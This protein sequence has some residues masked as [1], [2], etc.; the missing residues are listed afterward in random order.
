MHFC[1]CFSLGCFSL[2][3]LYSSNKY[4]KFSCCFLLHFGHRRQ[5]ACLNLHSRRQI[6]RKNKSR[7]F[8]GNN[9]T[10]TMPQKLFYN[11]SFSEATIVNFD[12]FGDVYVYTFIFK[13]TC[14]RDI[15]ERMKGIVMECKGDYNEAY[16]S[17]QSTYFFMCLFNHFNHFWP[18]SDWHIVK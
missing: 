8:L 10:N 17:F 1:C 12:F 11:S 18:F 5:R 3:I 9:G 16:F 6:S 2:F 13:K 15:R 4:F 14:S 7:E